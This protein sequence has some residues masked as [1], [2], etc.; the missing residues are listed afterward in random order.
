[1]LPD[2]VLP[3]QS[4]REV[5]PLDDGGAASR[6]AHHRQAYTTPLRQPA[7]RRVSLLGN[8]RP[9]GDA[10][11]LDDLAILLTLDLANVDAPQ[12]GN[13]EAP[14]VARIHLGRDRLQDAAD[15]CP[16]AL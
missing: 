2:R 4:P 12:P 1:M 11:Q 14:L 9:Q 15:D 13:T 16:Q 5:I 7:R 6:L 8:I 3:R 10:L